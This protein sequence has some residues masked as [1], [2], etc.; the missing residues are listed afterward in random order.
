MIRY[1]RIQFHA[2]RDTSG[3]VLLRNKSLANSSI[4]LLRSKSC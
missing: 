4:I 3:K 1:E 2:R